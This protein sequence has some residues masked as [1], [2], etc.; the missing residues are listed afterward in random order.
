MRIHHPGRPNQKKLPKEETG[1]RQFGCRHSAS[2]S[3]LP[4]KTSDRNNSSRCDKNR[5]RKGTRKR[6]KNRAVRKYQQSSRWNQ[7]SLPRKESR[8]NS[9]LQCLLL[10]NSRSLGRRDRY[11]NG[12]RTRLNF[13][14][15]AVR[16]PHPSS[17]AH[18]YH[19]DKNSCGPP[20]HH[21]HHLTPQRQAPS[22][23]TPPLP[24][25]P[26]FTNKPPSLNQQPH[27]QTP[28]PGAPTHWSVSRRAKNYGVRIYT[29][30][31]RWRLHGPRLRGAA[32][33]GLLGHG[34]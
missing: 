12:V 18:D 3:A 4:L 33:R 28:A 14:Y 15:P 13:I 19:E 21:R 20:I 8:Q 24:T 27:S 10:T 5:N 26:H 34:I 9:S 31:L 17:R 2:P 1:H 7:S 30:G 29:C 16:N 25:W 6:E 22:Q 32:R 11:R 23:R